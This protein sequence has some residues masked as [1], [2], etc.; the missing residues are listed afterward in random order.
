MVSDA[1]L[2]AGYDQSHPTEL[3][4][5]RCRAKWF[6]RSTQLPKFCPKGNCHSKYYWKKVK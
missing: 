5:Y 3:E 1:E 6:R 4:C 2:K